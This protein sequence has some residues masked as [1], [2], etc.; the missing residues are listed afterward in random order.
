VS[1]TT[2][3]QM[4]A[5]RYTHAFVAAYL[6]HRFS[7]SLA[8]PLAV[9][10]YELLDNALSYGSVSDPVLLELL[11]SPG[12]AAVRVSNTSIT[13]RVDV[14]IAH[15]ERL[16]G[17]GPVFVEEIKRSLAREM[18]RPMLGLAR[19]LHEAALDL[20][21]YVDDHRLALV[22]RQDK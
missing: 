10:A 15:I 18:A 22:A 20:E 14:L 17:P 4:N 11:E 2:G 12:L 19:I 13:A 5:L 21:L 9:A 8:E 6:R 1:I 7:P 16:G 3:V